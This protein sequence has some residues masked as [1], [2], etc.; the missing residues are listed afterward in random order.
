MPWWQLSSL[1]LS[2][3]NIVMDLSRA[4]HSS[5]LHQMPSEFLCQS[6]AHLS[7]ISS[8]SHT[9]AL[10]PHKVSA[11]TPDPFALPPSTWLCC[12]HIKP[13]PMFPCDC[14]LSADRR[15]RFYPVR[16]CLPVQTVLLPNINLLTTS[17]KGP[18]IQTVSASV[19]AFGSSSLLSVPWTVTAAGYAAPQKSNYRSSEH[20][21]TEIPHGDGKNSDWSTCVLWKFL[22]P[23]E[24]TDTIIVLLFR[25]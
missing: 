1:P 23:A 4:C 13:F 24:I 22:L 25:K 15:S 16:L 3:S 2:S 19:S 9:C 17:S 8:L 5:P 10:L 6:P 20:A 7:L 12:H 18:L 21:R 14:F 11:H